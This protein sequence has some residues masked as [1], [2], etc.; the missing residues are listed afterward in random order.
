MRTKLSVS[1]PQRLAIQGKQPV[2]RQWCDEGT[3]TP[4][5]FG[6]II[7][8]V[9]T[10]L[11]LIPTAAVSKKGGNGNGGGQTVVDDSSVDFGDVF[12]DLMHILRDG[13][14]GQPIFAQRWVE[15]P[16]DIQGWG[17]GYC[18]IGIDEYGAEILFKPYSCDLATP[19]DAV[20]VDYFGRLNASRVQERNQRMHFNETITNIKQAGVLRLDP[21]G[22]LELGFEL[23]LN[24]A[25]C[26]LDAD[27]CVCVFSETLGEGDC[28]WAT[29]DSPMENMALYQRMM[30]YGHIATDPEEVDLWWHGSPELPTPTHPALGPKDFDKFDKAGLSNWLPDRVVWDGDDFIRD[31]D[32]CFTD[33]SK[34]PEP[35]VPCLP[36]EDLT[37]EDF[38]TSADLLGAAGGKHN[39]FTE[40][41]VQYLNRFLRITQTTTFAAATLKTLPAMYQ[42]CDVYK[43]GELLIGD[44]WTSGEEAPET[45][46]TDVVV[47][48]YE[49]CDVFEVDGSI[50]NYADFPNVQELFVDFGQSAYVRKEI[51]IVNED[52]TPDVSIPGVWDNRL[53]TIA[54]E[55][56]LYI[57][58]ASKSPLTTSRVQAAGDA[59]V[60]S[61]PGLNSG[62]W[63]TVEEEPLLIWIEEVN[64]GYL[65]DT[66][67]HN[68]VDAASDTLRAIEYLHNYV[69]PENL[70]CTYELPDCH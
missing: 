32:D 3:K 52:P 7:L 14:T 28:L 64:Q 26:A 70:Y 1:Q 13:T 11:L 38:N 4:S 61:S 51:V 69:V 31:Y 37:K 30:K 10:L 42:S 50:P 66:N 41:L 45:W 47:L 55:A 44:P 24:T 5:R 46:D 54:L 20:E 58:P 17:W 29:V 21:T 12:G 49:N 6:W 63:L 39:F 16:A 23:E 53:A 15:M 65:P 68:F 34:K 40:H 36:P 60:K 59:S 8:I 57:E 33:D 67:I 19:D 56:E 2:G 9:M 22:R 43:D 27:D 35:I 48:A 25:A 18:A 62:I